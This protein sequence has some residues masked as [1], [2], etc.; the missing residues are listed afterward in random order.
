MN[1]NEAGRRTGTR[2]GPMPVRRLALGAAATMVAV[3]CGP[4][5]PT[6]VAVEANARDLPARQVVQEG[7]A[8]SGTTNTGGATTDGATN[9]GPGLEPNAGTSAGPD[10][11]P[12]FGPDPGAQPTAG[13]TTGNDEPIG[14]PGETGPIR[15]AS[16]GNYSGAAGPPQAAIANGAKIWA[17]YMNDQGG[18]FGRPIEFFLVDD[19]SDPA[20]HLAALKDMV[21][22]KG[23][24]AFVA[25]AAALT[26]DAGRD[27]LEEKQIPVFGGECAQP[28]YNTTR[29][30]MNPCPDVHIQFLG[31]FMNAAQY[32]TKIAH[33]YCRESSVCSNSNAWL[34]EFKDEAGLEIV[35]EAQV[36]LAQPDYT[37]ECR[38]ARDAGAEVLYTIIDPS[39]VER[40]GISCARQDYFPTFVQGSA[41]INYATKDAVPRLAAELPTFPFIGTE[42]PARNEFQQV[43]GAYL[44][45]HPGP[46]ETM[47]WAAA[48]LF[49]RSAIEAARMHGSLT[50]ATLIAGAH[51]LKDETL[52]GLTVPISYG[53]DGSVAAECWFAAFAEDGK[54]SRVN[55]GEPL[56]R[57]D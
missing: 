23:V 50:P 48:K 8:S 22:N 30:Y 41:T 17:Q 49:E 3:A 31:N 39:G 56:C 43:M 32:G 4:T 9:P 34:H 25:N 37:T 24:V 6:E 55:D 18:L 15:I 46:G 20:Q 7:D 38:N 42:T 57:G 47:G 11:G 44:A 19:K 52:G 29:W 51:T 36:L 26:V 13:P 5:I 10:V 54:W 35:Y 16:V 53:E 21:E 45:H 12:T 1:N 40:V 33:F 2:T 14:T 28:W 27:Y